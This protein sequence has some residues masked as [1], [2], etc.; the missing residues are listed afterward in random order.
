M[1]NA[2]I[3]F[4]CFF[5]VINYKTESSETWKAQPRLRGIC[6][7]CFQICSHHV[8]IRFPQVPKLFPNTPL[9]T[10]IAKYK[11]M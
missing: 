3:I 2:I 4:S 6:L 9:R 5:E 8:P 1:G 11:Q 7:H 10:P